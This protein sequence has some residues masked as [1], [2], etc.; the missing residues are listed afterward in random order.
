[1]AL[2]ALTSLYAGS[3]G[4]TLLTALVVRAATDLLKRVTGRCAGDRRTGPRPEI[5]VRPRAR[6]QSQ[7]RRTAPRLTDT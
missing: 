1:M 4:L 7:P 2:L 6:Q 3:A 5:D